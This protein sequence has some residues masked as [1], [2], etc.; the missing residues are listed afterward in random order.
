MSIITITT[1]LGYRDPYLAMVKG[2]LYSKQPTAKIVDLACDVNKHAHKEGAFALKIAL[3]YFP[4]DTI[5][6]F[7]VKLLNSSETISNLSVD[8]TRYLLCK[9]KNQYIVCPDNGL[10]TIIDREFNEPVYHIYF[11]RENQHAFYLRDIFTEIAHKIIS[12]IPLEDFCI[13]TQD[14]CKLY[15]FESFST[16]SNLQGMVIYED[17]FGNLVTSIT[18]EEFEKNVGN[19]RFSIALP[20]ANVTKIYSTYDDVKMGDVVCFFNSMNFLEIAL[21]GQS[22]TKIAM[23]SSVLTKYKIDKIIVEIYD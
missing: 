10:L 1:D 16:P 7:A 14:Y 21:L 13:E 9:Y 17:D 3:P 11:E 19:K 8:N 20:S 4:E 12:K 23:K 15:N 6:L 5:H 18:K 2:I 22:A